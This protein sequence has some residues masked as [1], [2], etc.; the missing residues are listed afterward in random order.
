LKQVKTFLGGS[1]RSS[2]NEKPTLHLIGIFHT[3]HSD[4]HSHCAFTGKALRFP[5][6]MQ[7]HGYKVVEYS[8]E[9]SE[10]TADEKHI[11]LTKEELF[12]M[13]TKKKDEEFYG[14]DAVVGSDHHK[15][16]EERLLKAM[17]E[18]VKQG[19]IICHPFGIAH[20]TFVQHFP[21]NHHVETGIGYPDCLDGTFKIF[22]SYAKMHYWHGK[23]GVVNGLNYSWVIPN[24]YDIDQW[25]PNYNKGKYIAFMGRIGDIKGLD[26]IVE[27]A[28]RSKIPVKV[29][30]Q[31]DPTPYLCDNIEYVGVLKGKERN[32]FI[33]NAVC[34]LMPTKYIE[35]FGGAGV[36]GLLCGTPLLAVDYG[37][38]VETVD[39]GENGFRCKTLKDWMDAI[40]SCNLLDRKKISKKAR[41]KYGLYSVGERYDQAFT[42]IDNL[43]K[44]GWYHMH[45]LS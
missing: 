32:E 36:E 11:M 42:Q 38:F 34:Q 37:A 26:T 28:K 3:V 2:Q 40:E 39:H 20:S 29:A 35:P 41:E 27:I 17:V 43:S 31:G 6:M 13:I 9:G 7:M 45:E 19:D 18:N 23:D 10:S 25:T 1:Q 15:L 12:S 44:G 8:N 4:E 21:N 5:K 30:G 24:Y 16:F 14:N 33:R 22:E